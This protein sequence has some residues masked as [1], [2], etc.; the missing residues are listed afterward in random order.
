MQFMRVKIIRFSIENLADRVKEILNKIKKI[1]KNN[2]V[3]LP[4]V[5]QNN[6]KQH[7]QLLIDFIQIN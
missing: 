3:L 2:T 1:N 4:F 6:K 5:S 7:K